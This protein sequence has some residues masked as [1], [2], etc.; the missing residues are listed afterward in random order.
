MMCMP[1]L[2]RAFRRGP[3][4]P[5]PVIPLLKCHSTLVTP[6][7]GVLRSSASL[8]ICERIRT[9]RNV[10]PTFDSCATPS[11]VRL[12]RY[13][14]PWLVIRPALVPPKSLLKN[15]SAAKPIAR[16]SATASPP[17]VMPNANPVAQSIMASSASLE[18]LP[19]TSRNTEPST[20]QGNRPNGSLK[21]TGSPSA[22]P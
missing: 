3:L 1:A 16:F 8:A 4:G 22:K 12:S 6:L 11:A 7:P 13:R 10:L 21:L 15:P 18:T 20:Q 5:I 14:I 9:V 2:V 17:P 19:A